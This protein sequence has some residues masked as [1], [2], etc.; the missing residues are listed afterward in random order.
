M[1]TYVPVCVEEVEANNVVRCQWVFALKRGPDGSV[2]WYKV[3]IMVKGFSQAYLIDYDETFAPVIKWVSICILL[4]L[5]AQLNLEVHQMDVKTA[6]LNR[7]LEHIIYMEPPPG[8]VD[9]G[10]SGIIWKL[11]KSLY[12][13]KQASH[14][15][16]EKAQDKFNCL[17]FSQSD[18]DYSVFVHASQDGHFC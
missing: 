10:S 17:S 14:A 4:A 9:F 13:L 2:E 8:C 6:F 1:R 12:G 16:Y 7:D 15:W 5:A 11:E 18:A 3:R